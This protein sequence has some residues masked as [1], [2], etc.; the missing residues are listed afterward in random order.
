[1]GKLSVTPGAGWC[2]FCASRGSG[3]TGQ[4]EAPAPA[5]EG[6]VEDTEQRMAIMCGARQ[7]LEAGAGVSWESAGRGGGLRRGRGGSRG[8]Q[9]RALRGHRGARFSSSVLFVFVPFHLSERAPG[10]LL[11]LFS[12]EPGRQVPCPQAPTPPCCWAG[13]RLL[14]TSLGC[15]GSVPPIPGGAG[16]YWAGDHP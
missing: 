4:R 3:G 16:F 7:F 1:M 13:Q 9:S 12:L 14:L 5:F 6:E 2:R 10:N 15:E 8:S 11:A